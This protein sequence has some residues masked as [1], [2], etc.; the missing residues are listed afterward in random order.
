MELLI[1]LHL[2]ENYIPLAT[3]S[4]ANTP[5]TPSE[6][7]GSKGK[8]KRHSEGLIT[9][10]RFTPIAT[11]RSRK[12]QNSASI[13]GKPTLTTCT[14]KI[15]I[16]NP[17][18]TSKGKLPRSADNKFVQGTVKETLASKGTSQ[19]TEKACPEPEDLE[20]DTLDTVVDG[21]TIREIISTLPFTLQFNRNL[22]PEDWKDMDQVFQLHQ[23]LKDW[24]QWSMDNKRFNLAS[25]WA[26]LEA[27]FEKVC[28]K[29]IDFKDLMIITKGWNPTRQ[30]R[31]LEARAQRIR[32]NEATIQAIREQHQQINDQESPLFTIP[33]GLR[34]KKR[35]QGEKQDL[36]QP[37]AER[38]RPHDPGVDGLGERSEQEPEVAANHFRI[39]SPSNI[40]I[41][42]T[43]PEHNIVTSE[44]N[45]NS[46]TLW[47]Q[48][49]KFSEKTQ[50]QFA[51]LEASHERMK[52]LTASMDKI[53]K[54]LQ[55]GHAQLRKASEETN[56][57]LNLVF[58]KQNHSKR[59]G[60]CL[61]EDNIS[62]SEKEALKQ[63]P[64]ASSWP[65]F[66]G[67]GEY[68]LMELIHYI[69]GLFID[70]PSIPDYWITARL[71]TAFKG[72]ASFW[73]TEMEEI[74][75]RRNWPWWKSQIIQN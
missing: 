43:Q 48:M 5:V 50:K 14:G 38:I 39:S 58:E 54:T 9:E 31:L 42:P 23:L 41:T 74:H 20:E 73:Y 24:F 21:K 45:L 62:Y 67:T 3:Q 47:L 66:S 15:T 63:L 68:G 64:E 51:E 75:H 70:V 61:D 1:K 53:V 8:G 11:Q 71:C 13:Q 18:V 65:K 59:D 36:F 34:E 6:P 7:E 17:V 40:N 44:S 16:I 46:D 72:H 35:I 60:A 52:K 12:P 32:E 25:H 56:K 33:G 55:E 57:R 22:K 49:S 4:Q 28:L 30:F 69:D 27:S 2:E 37:K 10:K 26:E 29:E 19:R